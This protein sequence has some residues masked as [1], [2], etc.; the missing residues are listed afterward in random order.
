MSPGAPLS[1]H[2]TSVAFHGDVDREC[3]HRREHRRRPVASGDTAR[4]HTAAGEV[5]SVDVGRADDDE[6]RGAA[7][8]EPDGLACASR[9]AVVAAR[10]AVLRIGHGVAGAPDDD[11]NVLEDE[12][13]LEDD[14]VDDDPLNDEEIDVNPP[15]GP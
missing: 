7:V 13:A 3:L 6:E 14:D 9:L 10:A 5:G 8:R 2:A 11:L 12:D 1:A 15:H 4:L